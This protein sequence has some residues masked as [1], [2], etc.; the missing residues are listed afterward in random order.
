MADH[1]F[2]NLSLVSA[3]GKAHSLPVWCF[4]QTCAW[5]R[6]VRVPQE[7]EILWQVN[8][9]LAYGVRGIQYFTFWQ[10]LED[11]EWR[12]GMVHLDGRL[13]PQYAYVKAANACIRLSQDLLMRGCFEGVLVHLSSP[14]PVPKEDIL[15]AFGPLCGLAGELP[16]LVG[17]FSGNGEAGY[18][19]VNNTV[20]T[21]GCVRLLFNRAVRGQVRENGNIRLFHGDSLKLRLAAGDGAYVQLS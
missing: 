20:T 8:T 11:G 1:Y 15:P 3:A 14:A 16:A 9:A 18:Y 21:A 4:I 17:C 12:G 2:L 7:A 19:V 13:N 10:P 6:K 5:N